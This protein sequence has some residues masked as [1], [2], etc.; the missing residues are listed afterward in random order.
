MFSG[1]LFVMNKI[2]QARSVTIENISYWNQLACHH[3]P[4]PVES[5]RNH[6]PENVKKFPSP[7]I[8]ATSVMQ[9]QCR[10]S[11]PRKNSCATPNRVGKFTMSYRKTVFE[12]IKNL[13]VFQLFPF[14]PEFGSPK[15]IRFLITKFC[16]RF[17]TEQM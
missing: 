13:T 1:I 5:I 12:I 11:A 7:A 10:A 14:R 15:L 17:R 16:F 4:S 6:H 2:I 3:P 9:Q 8:P